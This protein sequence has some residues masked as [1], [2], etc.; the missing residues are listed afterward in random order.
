MYDKAKL[1]Q[2][3][4]YALQQ[5]LAF[6]PPPG[7]EA[8][9]G[10]P[11]MAMPPGG[12][13]P[14]DPAMM[15]GAPPMDPAM[16]GGAPPMDPSM[17]AMGDQEGMKAAI[18]SVLQEM[19]LGGESA[20]QGVAAP[21]KSGNK[22]DEAISTLR[23]DL[24]EQMKEQQKILVAALRNA[25]IDISL[26]DL[27]GL[28]KGPEQSQQQ[29]QSPELAQ[30]AP[31]TSEGIEPGMGTSAPLGASAKVGSMQFTELDNRD[32]E[33]LTKLAQARGNLQ[34]AAARLNPYPAANPS[35]SELDYFKG[36]Y[37]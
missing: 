5:K 9:M 34:K 35:Q 4:A 26:G 15:G 2:I 3:M 32:V 13:P 29:Q 8:P 22:A 14:M 25:N 36:L 24:M 17:Q 16:M 12:A 21:K 19:G 33:V 6:V 1:Q 27:Y 37:R 7:A 23:A 30:P 18:R 20:G 10:D 28:E 11:M 31:G